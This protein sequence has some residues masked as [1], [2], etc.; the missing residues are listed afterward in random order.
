[1]ENKFYNNGE[2]Q[3]AEYLEKNKK[4]DILHNEFTS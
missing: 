1:M 4:K 2:A 3:F